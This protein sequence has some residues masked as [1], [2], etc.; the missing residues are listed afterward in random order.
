MTVC[1]Y[2]HPSS[3]RVTGTLDYIGD[4]GK[5]GKKHEEALQTGAKA[6]AAASA[7]FGQAVDHP[8]TAMVLGA[9]GYNLRGLGKLKVRCL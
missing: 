2:W 4:N 6:L 9:L 8:I 3:C 1:W 5:N 7:V